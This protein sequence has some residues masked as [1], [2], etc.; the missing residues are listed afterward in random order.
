MATVAA[1]IQLL[2]E[3]KDKDQRVVFQFYTADDFVIDN[4]GQDD[5]PSQEIFVE[6]VEQIED[7]IWRGTWEDLASEI[8]RLHAEAVSDGR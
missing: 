3:I 5:V 4:D 1:L 7:Y 8:V 6:A 2:E